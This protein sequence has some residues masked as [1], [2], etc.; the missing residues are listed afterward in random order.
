MCRYYPCT[1][2]GQIKKGILEFDFADIRHLYQPGHIQ[3]TLTLTLESISFAQADNYLYLHD[4]QDA[5]ENGAIDG[6]EPIVPESVGTAHVTDLAV[7]GDTISFDVTQALKYDL[8]APDQSTFSGFVLTAN[9][10]DIS[11]FLETPT[12]D[13]YD[14]TGSEYAPRL[15]ITDISQPPPTVIMLSSFDAVASFHKVVIRWSTE[16]E[17]ENAGFNIYRSESE[18]GEYTKI[19]NPDSCTRVTHAGHCIYE[20]I[21]RM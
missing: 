3:A 12:F 17:T 18:N 19:N 14:H 9:N 1:Y 7:A 4:L 2:F 8:F 20:F 15:T 13:F 5:H 10:T 21:D 16:S 11:Y 6:D